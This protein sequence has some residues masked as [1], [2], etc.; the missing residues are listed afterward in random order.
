MTGDAESR[1]YHRA[2]RDNRRYRFATK[3]AA[4]RL[5]PGRVRSVL[6]SE[7]YTT[8]TAALKQGCAAAGYSA[9]FVPFSVDVLTADLLSAYDLV[10][11]LSI[12]DL[13]ALVPHRELIRE[14]PIPIPSYSAIALCADKRLFAR[15]LVNGGFGDYVPDGPPMSGPERFPY[16]VKKVIDEGSANCHLVVGPGRERELS[17]LVNSS[18]YLTQAYI[19]GAREYATH[20]VFRDGRVVCALEFEYVFGASAPIK[21]QDQPLRIGL[22]ACPHLDLFAAVLEE[23][24]FE[25]LCC[26]NYKYRDGIPKILEINPR[27]GG[28]LARFFFSFLRRL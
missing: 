10:V 5:R 16:I 26:V 7:S 6:F 15:A 24:G 13:V 21:M 22:R 4:A 17:A 8:W 1:R 18:D 25:G 28:S 20:V 23:V 11:P 9:S 27:M 3:F 19:P 14:N 2:G 12:T